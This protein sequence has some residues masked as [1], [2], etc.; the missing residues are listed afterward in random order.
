VRTTHTA[1]NRNDRVSVDYT[2]VVPTGWR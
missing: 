2:I 1:R